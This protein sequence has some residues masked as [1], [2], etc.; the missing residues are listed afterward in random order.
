MLKHTKPERATR[1][2]QTSPVTFSP[3]GNSCHLLLQC[4]L[5]PLAMVEERSKDRGAKPVNP[6]SFLAEGWTDMGLGCRL[7]QFT[8]SCFLS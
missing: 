8:M 7:L 1:S 4:A 6:V 5:T 2:P 3:P